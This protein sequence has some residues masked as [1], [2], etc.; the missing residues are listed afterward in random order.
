M[1]SNEI[2]EKVKEFTKNEKYFEKN[3]RCVEHILNAEKVEAEVIKNEYKKYSVLK[4]KVDD[5]INFTL[6]FEFYEIFNDIELECQ[7]T[8]FEKDDAVTASELEENNEIFKSFIENKIKIEDKGYLYLF[9]K[10]K[11][12]VKKINKKSKNYRYID[13]DTMMLKIEKKQVEVI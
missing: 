1:L 11:N 10:Y 12:K 2:T 6:P 9:S 13:C 5:K 7:L 4:F 8:I 3:L